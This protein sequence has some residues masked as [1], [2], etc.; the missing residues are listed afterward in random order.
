MRATWCLLFNKATR[1]ELKAP[2][3]CCQRNAIL[4]RKMLCVPGLSL[5]TR[6]LVQLQQQKQ[7]TQLSKYAC[8]LFMMQICAEQNW[9][10]NANICNMHASTKGWLCKVAKCASSTQQ[11]AHSELNNKFPLNG[12]SGIWPRRIKTDVVI[13]FPPLRSRRE[14]LKFWNKWGLFRKLTMYEKL[15]IGRVS[16]LFSKK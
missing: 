16:S 5:Y 4:Q 8:V 14:K 2:L 3:A 11:N 9:K 7:E 12:V 1:K 10:E 13:T 15:W 6:E